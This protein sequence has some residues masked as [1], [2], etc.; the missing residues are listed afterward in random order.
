MTLGSESTAGPTVN[1]S[2][3][4]SGGPA[5]ANGGRSSRKAPAAAIITA[6]EPSYDDQLRSRRTRYSIMMGLRIP[7]LILA[8]FFYQTPWLAITIAA[9]SIP[10]PWMAV[11]IANDRPAQKR[12]RMAPVTVNPERA[13]PPG[14]HEIV[15]SAVDP[16]PR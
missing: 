1:P 4:P 9:L 6:A 14:R 7:C 13:L 5:P 10:L 2:A 8:A 12:K 11:L 3:N 16:D 15:D